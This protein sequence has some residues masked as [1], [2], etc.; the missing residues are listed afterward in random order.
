MAG[1]WYETNLGSVTTWSSGGTPRKDEPSFWNGT[2]PWISASS[3][4]SGRLSD[5]DLKITTSGLEHGSRQADKESVL[6]L[7]RGSELHK[8]IPIGIAMRPV[9]FNQD[10]KAIRAREELLNWFLFYWFLGNER[11]LL[12]MVEFTGIGAGKLDIDRLK[13]LKIRIPNL[14][15]QEKI[16]QFVKNLDDKIELN[17]KMNETLEAMARAL[18]KSWFVDFD[19]VRAKAEGRDTGLPKEI[20]DLFPDEFE[21]SELGEIPKG[22]KV[23]PFL[24]TVEVIGGGT[25]KTTVPD[26]WNG[27]IPWFSVV[28]APHESDVWVVDTEKKITPEGVENSSTKVL[29]KG[30]TIISARGTVGRLAVAGVPMA[31]NQSC[32]GLRGVVPD[33]TL[34]TYFSTKT[35]VGMLQKHAHGSVFDTITRETLSGVFVVMPGENILRVFETKV[36]PLVEGIRSRL[37]E[38]QSLVKIR[39]ALLPVLINGSVRVE[40]LA[41]PI[42]TNGR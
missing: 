25:P 9:A 39:D 1:E 23:K 11:Q 5:S 22:W 42:S 41:V 28:D 36:T 16:V 19:P 26:Y 27:S 13:K 17:R 15:E 40:E 10:V 8:R 38:T 29:P 21:D 12:E 32:Y 3:M 37:L 34:F 4:K 30:T 33:T 18:F 31:M 7:V 6:L 20:A 14:P 35:L 24:E 2:I